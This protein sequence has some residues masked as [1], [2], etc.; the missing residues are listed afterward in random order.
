M[1]KYKFKIGDKVRML[2]GEST[3]NVG[4]CMSHLIGETGTITRRYTYCGEATYSV[5]SNTWSWCDDWME[6]VNRWEKITI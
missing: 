6:K 2:M 4:Y 5:N 3:R 1:E